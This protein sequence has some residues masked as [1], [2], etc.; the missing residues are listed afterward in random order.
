L[1]VGNGLSVYTGSSTFIARSLAKVGNIAIT[2]ADGVSGNPTIDSSTIDTNITTNATAITT[3]QT[4]LANLGFPFFC[5]EQGT[6]DNTVLV[7]AGQVRSNVNPESAAVD[8]AANGASAVTFPVVTADSRI[9]LLVLNTNTQ[10]FSR[11]AGSQAASPV[12]PV[13]PTDTNTIVLCEVTVNDT[14]TVVINDADIRNVIAKIPQPI[15]KLGR[16]LLH[17]R[18]ASGGS[19][20]LNEDGGSGMSFSVSGPSSGSYDITL[21]GIPSEFSNVYIEATL[22]DQTFGGR[23]GFAKGITN[24]SATTGYPTTTGFRVYLEQLNHLTCGSCPYMDNAGGSAAWSFTVY[25]VN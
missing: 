13:Y 4:D 8:I 24:K 10:A 23:T 1:P 20:D 11:I 2:N 25:G 5:K 17:G 21:T 3:L 7:S 18:V 16:P 12:P 9:D 19:I 15:R 6:P 14:V 22:H